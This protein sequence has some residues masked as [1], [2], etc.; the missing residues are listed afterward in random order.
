MSPT[1]TPNHRGADP[2]DVAGRTVHR[3]GFGA[4]R[5]TDPDVW[6]PP[7]DRAASCP[8]RPAPRRPRHLKENVVTA[9]VGLDADQLARLTAAG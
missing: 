8:A 4:M 9:Q 1:A 3:L 5:L 7:A 2:F 6:G